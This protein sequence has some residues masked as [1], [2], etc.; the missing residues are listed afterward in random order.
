MRIRVLGF[1]GCPNLTPTVERVRRVAAE[2]GIEDPVEI[3]EVRS[4]EQAADT[5]F[6][7]SP[8]VQIDGVDIEVS[9]RARS[10]F[11][12][13]CRLYGSSGTPPGDMIAAALREASR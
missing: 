13:A 5:G 1:D 12:V 9:S 2:L 7:G 10:D 11:A 6:L 8:T 4:P 3:V